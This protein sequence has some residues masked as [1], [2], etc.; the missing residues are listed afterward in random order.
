[1]MIRLWV[2]ALE[3]CRDRDDV[4]VIVVTGAG[5]AF[6]SGG[7][8]PEMIERL[9]SDVQALSRFFSQFAVQLLSNL[10]VIIGVLILL[11]FFMTRSCFK[12]LKKV[13]LRTPKK[14]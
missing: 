1:M 13:C 10:L 14:Y 4:K 11:W 2:A 8:I 7:D 9:D 6:C 3:G 5:K 12:I